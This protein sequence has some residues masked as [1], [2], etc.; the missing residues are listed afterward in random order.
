MLK[1]EYT[2]SP[3]SR[4]TTLADST[5]LIHKEKLKPSK[6][7]KVKAVYHDPCRLGRRLGVFDEPREVLASIPGLELLEFERSRK[8]SLCCGGGGGV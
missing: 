8:N 1:E 6:E 4:S 7:V 5:P 2:K 3:T